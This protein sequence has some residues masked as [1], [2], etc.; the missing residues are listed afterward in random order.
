MQ[1]LFIAE[2]CLGFSIIAMLIYED[3]SLIPPIKI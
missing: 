1:V 3:Y 2:L